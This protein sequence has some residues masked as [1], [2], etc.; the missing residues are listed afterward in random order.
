MLIRQDPLYHKQIKTNKPIYVDRTDRQFGQQSYYF[1][2]VNKVALV[3]KALV[4]AA[5]KQRSI[6]PHLAFGTMSQQAPISPYF[7]LP[8]V[9]SH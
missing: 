5:D 8:I 1:E 3:L 4:Y 9:R 7:K 2:H 6:P